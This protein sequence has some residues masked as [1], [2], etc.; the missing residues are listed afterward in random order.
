MCFVD[1]ATKKLPAAPNIT[2]KELRQLVAE[3]IDLKHIIPT[4]AIFFKR[5]SGTEPPRCIEDDEQ[6]LK[7]IVE[8][9][10]PNEADPSRFLVKAEFTKLYTE[11]EAKNN[12]LFM[13]RIF[14]K[15]R[16][17]GKEDLVFLNYSYLQAVA[18]VIDNSYPEGFLTKEDKYKGYIPS[19][20]QAAQKK[21]TWEKLIL[22]AHAKLTGT[23]KEDAMIK[24]LEIVRKWHFYGSAFWNA[25]SVN[26]EAASLPDQVV[27]AVN[28]IGIQLLK[29]KT[30]EIVSTH[31]FAD[32]ATWA[33]RQN[34]FAF[35]H[36]VLSK[37][38]LQFQT[39]HGKEIVKTL[40]A[41]SEFLLEERKKAMDN[42]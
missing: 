42:K 40:Q 26:K 19:T 27:I 17:V 29:P 2:G 6:V 33:Y 32:I 21:E 20:L 39:I 22:D 31:R 35:V 24:Y 4:F 41:Y 14:L 37:Q 28:S 3:K 25:T 23:R 34:G 15:H 9:M 7:C 18:D 16:L 38:K 11:W 12:L 13:R 5:K 8:E 10:R 1:G 30:K 36:G